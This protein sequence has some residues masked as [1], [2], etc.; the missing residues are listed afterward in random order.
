MRM[1]DEWN[2]EFD[3][4]ESL[5]VFFESIGIRDFFGGWA[6]GAYGIDCGHITKGG[7]SREAWEWAT[8]EVVTDQRSWLRHTTKPPTTM[9][10]RMGPGMS[11]EITDMGEIENPWA[12]APDGTKHTFW[13]AVWQKEAFAI[14]VETETTRALM[15]LPEL[16]E[17]FGVTVEDGL[18]PPEPEPQETPGLW[19]R[20]IQGLGRLFLSRFDTPRD[21]V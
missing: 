10:S 4:D 14:L 9:R 12:T 20:A 18:V 15:T 21:S 17:L 13:Y 11:M 3:A 5:D 1:I 8:S 6:G 16:R 19:A 7:L 2:V